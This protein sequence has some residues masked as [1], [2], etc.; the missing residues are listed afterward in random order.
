MRTTATRL[1]HPLP[2]FPSCHTKVGYF[3]ILV[4]VQQEVFQVSIAVTD[5]LT[6]AVVYTACMICWK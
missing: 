1:E 3:D 4:F 5:V 2:S 6:V